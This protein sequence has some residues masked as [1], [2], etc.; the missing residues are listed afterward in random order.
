[1]LQRLGRVSTDESSPPPVVGAGA[2][3]AAVAVV[4]V[5]VVVVVDA[6]APRPR[7]MSWTR[8]P[9]TRTGS[10]GT[11]QFSY[12]RTTRAQSGWAAIVFSDPTT[13]VISGSRARISRNRSIGAR[14]R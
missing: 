11:H 3:G 13:R 9:V 1:R 5:V 14:S 2:A 8:A 10:T 7:R 12:R 4:V 6:A